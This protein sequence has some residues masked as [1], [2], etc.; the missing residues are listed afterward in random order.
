MLFTNEQAGH[1]AKVRELVR[2]NP[3]TP[4]RPELERRIVGRAFRPAGRAWNLRTSLDGDRPNLTAVR[5]KVDELADVVRAGLR[6]RRVPADAEWP[7]IEGVIVHHLYYRYRDPF[8]AL[9]E[10]RSTTDGKRRVGFFSDF[11]SAV[12]SFEMNRA[13]W[14]GENPAH[15]FACFFQILRAFVFI[16]TNIVGGSRPA[17]SLRARVWESVFGHDIHRYERGLFRHL[18]DVAT[19]ILGPTGTGKELVAKAIA[20]SRYLPFNPQAQSFEHDHLAAFHP[21]NLAALSPTLIESEIFG[22]RRGAFTGALADRRGYLEVC[23]EHGAVFLDEIGELDPAL[24]VK[25]LRV[26]QDRS[27]QRLGETTSRRF[28][29]KVVAAT[30]R[31]LGAALATGRLR[32]DFYYRLC[33]DVIVTPGLAAQL[34]DNPGDLDNLTSFIADRVAGPEAGPEV[35]HEAATFIRA[36]IGD[37]YTWPGNFRELEQCVRNVMVRGHYRPALLPRSKAEELAAAFETGSMSADDL[38]SAYARLVYEKVGS[39][40]QAAR[41]LGLDP[42]TLRA[43]VRRGMGI[44]RKRR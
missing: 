26:L 23:P 14:L 44:R 17:A 15:L 36:E 27:F 22:H 13:S 12:R 21:V 7:L 39:Y 37:D 10:G 30:H 9:L 5:H 4:A 31:D 18:G 24:Q 16:Y 3:F 34:V 20:L 29:G 8:L 35:A 32:A 11:L 38:V 1:A 33:A 40:R 41:R 19:L 42:R 43:K 25:L 28:A 6:A 2:C